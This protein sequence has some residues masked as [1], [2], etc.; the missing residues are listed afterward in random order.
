M[1]EAS[2]KANRTNELQ[3]FSDG[4]DDYLTAVLARVVASQAVMRHSTG[5]FELAYDELAVELA[6]RIGA[7]VETEI[8]HCVAEFV[9]R[10]PPL[11][12]FD[13]QARV[14]ENS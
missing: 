5:P 4:G 1:V 7:S 12:G 10:T 8:E 11:S 6:G 9:P 14:P 13:Q 2:A 3:L